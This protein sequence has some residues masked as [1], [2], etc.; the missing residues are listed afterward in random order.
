MSSILFIANVDWFFVSHRLP[1][2]V[3]AVKNGYD[4]HLA[5][6]ITKETQTI[7]R[8]GIKVHD[9]SMER[10]G[11][12]IFRELGSFARIFRIIREVKPDIIHLISI[13][14]TIYGGLA[15]K[16]MRFRNVVISISGLG[17][18]YIGNEL[19]T[20]MLRLL[21]SVFY[22]MAIK[23]DTFKVI[24]QNNDDLKTFIDMKAIGINDAIVIR[25][26]GVDLKEFAPSIEPTGIPVAM[27]V[28]RLLI[29][30]GVREFVEAAKILKE[31]NCLVRMVIV[32]G[33]DPGNPKTVTEEQVKQWA[34]AGLIEY[35]GYQENVASTIKKSNMVVLPS[36]R[37]GMPKSL[38]EAAASARAIVTTDVPGCRD[39]IIPNVMG[40]LVPVRDAP[41]LADGIEK[42][43]R[44]TA[45]RTSMAKAGR[46]FAEEN[47]D[48]IE[49]V[50]KHISIYQAM[51]EQ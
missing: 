1:I 35:W 4:T 12:A 16:L 5:C 29:D 6:T 19:K 9:L 17:Y 44:D 50:K 7:T 24:F 49:V 21:I 31:R 25:G 15:C 32:G 48:I 39:A 38:L 14:P 2:A 3:E 40:L 33:C 43:C 51:L 45:L 22:R 28:S 10:S 20:R 30:K 18:V 37:E 23:K 42:L 46:L 36:Y 8:E 34:S 27:L 13:K 26:S 41:R 11:T 47:F